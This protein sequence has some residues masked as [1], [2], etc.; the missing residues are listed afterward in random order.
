MKRC[1]DF[2]TSIMKQMEYVILVP[3]EFLH[4]VHSRVDFKTST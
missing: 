2:E 4:S 3:E 1:F